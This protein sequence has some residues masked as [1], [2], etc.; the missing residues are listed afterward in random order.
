MVSII[1]PVYNGEKWLREAIE[2]VR[3]QSETDWELIII[4]DSSE[5]SS[6]QLA[7]S[8]ASKDSRIKT[9]QI[10][11]SGPGGARNKGLEIAKGNFIMFLDADDM[12]L[13]DSIK[14]LLEFEALSKADIIQGITL[15]RS[16]SFG[17]KIPRNSVAN[18]RKYF[19]TYDS[20][21][22]IEEV[23]YQRGLDC[24]MWGKL[25]KANLFDNIRFRARVTYEDLDIFYRLFEKAEKIIKIN[26]PVYFYR[27]NPNGISHKWNMTRLD[28][29][30]IT[31]RIEQHFCEKKPELLKAAQERRYS[32]NFNMLILSVING[33]KSR[34]GEC[35]KFIKFHRFTSL[36]NPKARMKNRLAS[37][38]FWI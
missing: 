1:L 4:D 16:I 2:S 37:L 10:E 24:S 22:A 12:L 7:G 17:N 29:L 30:D 38:L 9:F 35:R 18:K 21:E 6:Y 36:K 8:A 11:H 23:L 3:L 5:D 20:T 15:K 27:K 33:E 14:I 25:F 26:S 13:P 31:K 19:K 28:V 34:I 32:A